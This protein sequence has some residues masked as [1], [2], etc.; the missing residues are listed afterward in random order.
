MDIPYRFL[1]LTDLATWLLEVVLIVLLGSFKFSA[2]SEEVV[3]NLAGVEYPTVGRDSHRS[4][5]P[6][7]LTSEGTLTPS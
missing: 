1:V 4:V 3:W 2:P 6:D 7:T 5:S